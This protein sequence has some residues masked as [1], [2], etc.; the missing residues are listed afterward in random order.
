MRVRIGTRGSALA[1][2]QAGSVATALREVGAE[3]EI[4]SMRTEGDRR[5]GARLAEIGGKGLFVR[6]IEQ[7]L[8]DGRVDVAVH[9]LKDLPAQTPDGLELAA[10]PPRE[11]PRDVLVARS[12]GGLGALPPGAVIG[13]SSLRRRALILAARSDLSVIPLRGNVDTR[14]AKLAA[15]EC[16]GV[17]LAAAG[18]RRLSLTP[19]HEF[20]LD[21]ET[22]VPAVGQGILVL[23]TR[24]GD[25]AI[26]DLV[27]G[28]NDPVTRTCA[29]AERAY[30]RRLGASCN[31]PMAAHA[32]LVGV[33]DRPRLLMTALVASE[34]GRQVLR[35]DSGGA[36]ED[37]EAIGRGLAELMLERGAAEVT[38]LEPSRGIR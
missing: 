6:E 12:D 5:L 35:A 7:A 3:V 34:D 14:L 20:A 21:V 37:A 31:T 25:A 38:A 36:P 17:I 18:L 16:D 23:E 24:A 1:L 8:S 32:T 15:G 26:G 2:A 9:S 29:L 11:D 22:F 10:F 13:T 19:A 30:L 4:V 28:L 27:A 33:A